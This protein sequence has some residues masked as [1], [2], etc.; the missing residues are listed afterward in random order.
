MVFF[1]VLF[2]CLVLCSSHPILPLVVPA[3][4]TLHSPIIAP[5]SQQSY[6]GQGLLGQTLWA[7]P[8]GHHILKRSPHLVAPLAHGALGLGPVA[9]IGH[10]ASVA[11][12]APVAVSQQSRLDVRT[13][14]A[15]VAAPVVPVVKPIAPVLAAPLLQKALVA[16]PLHYGVGHGL[17]GAGLGH[18]GYGHAA[19][20]SHL[21]HY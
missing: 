15:V 19:A 9:P 11:H 2:A 13:S 12:I 21:G 3:A 20:L 17:Y 8:L 16:A 6:I 5:Y 4:H 7:K 18:Y 10:V 1:A 14:P